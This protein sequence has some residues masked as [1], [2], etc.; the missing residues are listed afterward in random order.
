MITIHNCEQGTPEWF[1]CRAGLPTASEF[2]T[3]MAKGRGGGESVTRRKYMLTLLG[4]RLTGEVA[5]TYSNGHM[6]RGKVMEQEARDLYQFRTDNELSQ[7]GFVRN[8]EIAA[9]ASPDSLIGEDGL[10]EIKTALPHIQLER[11]LSDSLPAEHKAQVQGQLLVTGR[12][13]VDFISYWPKLPLF[14]V[15][16]ER[17]EPYIAT[18]KQAIADFNG[19]LAEL[20]KRFA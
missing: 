16:V 15:Q 3:V 4:E 13:W 10:L 17:D 11:L 18:L 1:A 8:D 7:V 12:Q 5:E 9:G 6:E 19:E 14:R 20:H 2:A